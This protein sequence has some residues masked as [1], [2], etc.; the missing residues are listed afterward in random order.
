MSFNDETQLGLVLTEPQPLHYDTLPCKSSISVKLDT[1]HF[2]AESAFRIGI[3]NQSVLLGTG[4]SQCD[5]I[6]GLWYSEQHI[7]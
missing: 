5:W 2:V 3:L 1:H 6:Y 4:F 7:A